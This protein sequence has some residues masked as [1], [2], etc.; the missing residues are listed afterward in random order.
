[1]IRIYTSA[2]SA[3]V[4]I[5]ICKSSAPYDL[6]QQFTFLYFLEDFCNWGLKRFSACFCCFNWTALQKMVRSTYLCQWLGLVTPFLEADTVFIPNVCFCTTRLPSEHMERVSCSNFTLSTF[7]I[8][9]SLA[10]S[11]SPTY[12]QSPTFNFQTPL[13]LFSFKTFTLRD[14][15]WGN[16]TLSAVFILSDFIISK[17]Q[18]YFA[19]IP[20]PTFSTGLYSSIWALVSLVI[21]KFIFLSLQ[22]LLYILSTLVILSSSTNSPVFSFSLG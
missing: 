6:Y 5:L 14:R 7:F 1:M 4:L 9:L 12:C 19:L 11:S 17:S 18:D 21:I 10:S 22:F 15:L 20:A 8:F 2:P 16:H 3:F 13:C